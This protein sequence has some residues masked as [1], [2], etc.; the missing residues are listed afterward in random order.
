MGTDEEARQHIVALVQRLY[1]FGHCT[2]D[3]EMELWQRLGNT[4]DLLEVERQVA[5]NQQI[6]AHEYDQF[7]QELSDFV[8]QEFK[9]FG[10]DSRC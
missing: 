5:K 10:R 4:L 2:K 8:N 9:Q 6:M 7:V 3:R 1:D